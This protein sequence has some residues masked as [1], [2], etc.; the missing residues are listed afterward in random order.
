MGFALNK[1]DQSCPTVITVLL[2]SADPED[3]SLMKVLQG[4]FQ[5]Y[6]SVEHV[7]GRF[8]KLN[9]VETTGEIEGRTQQVRLI[10]PASPQ[11]KEDE[12]EDGDDE[13]NTPDE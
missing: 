3:L 7:D 5:H 8:L 4:A 1:L 2:D 13:V 6:S 9:I 12:D 11:Y 10:V